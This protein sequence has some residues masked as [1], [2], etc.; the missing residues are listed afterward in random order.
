M[1]ITFDRRRAVSPP[2]SQQFCLL[3][4][5]KNWPITFAQAPYVYQA[6]RLRIWIFTRFLP[7]F[8]CANDI[9]YEEDWQKAS[10]I[11]E[12]RVLAGVDEAKSESSVDKIC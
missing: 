5:L 8:S 12:K 9:D 7:E 4:A 6:L 1:I 11:Y 10:N 3:P 2:W